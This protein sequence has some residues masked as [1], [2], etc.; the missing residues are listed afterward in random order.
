MQKQTERQKKEQKKQ[1]NTNEYHLVSE[2]TEIVLNFGHSTT[3]PSGKFKPKTILDAQPVDLIN[4]M[5]Q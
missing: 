5:I 2:T 4:I 3:K 1:I